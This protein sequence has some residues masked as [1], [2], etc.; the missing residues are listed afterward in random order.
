MFIFILL[1]LFLY[2]CANV[3]SWF[4]YMLRHSAGYL[5]S[6]FGSCL[7]ILEAETGAAAIRAEECEPD[8]DC[9]KICREKSGRVKRAVTVSGLERDA[10]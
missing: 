10:T 4:I 5:S 3:L 1:L 6:N 7:L 2:V 9:L 8:N